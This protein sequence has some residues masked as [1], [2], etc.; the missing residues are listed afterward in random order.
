MINF[1]LV[2]EFQTIHRR[3]FE[4]D[5]PTILDPTNVRPIVDGEYLQLTTA[6]K[7]ARGGNNALAGSPTPDDEATVPSFA[8]FAE[9]GRYE[10]QAIQKGPFLYMAPYEADTLIFDATNGAP[11][12]AIALGAPV[13]VWDMT[14]GG[15]IRRGLSGK[16]GA[17]AFIIGYV[18]RMPAYNS[19]WLRFQHLA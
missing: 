9:R 19:N 18:T 6:Y 4:F 1:K 13:T 12:A 15:I 14:L 8:Y 3:P 16:I 11:G 17:S 5:A 10:V 2:S 7:M